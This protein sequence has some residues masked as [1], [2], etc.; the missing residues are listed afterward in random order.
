MMRTRLFIDSAKTFLTLANDIYVGKSLEVY[1]EWSYDEIRLLSCLLDTKSNVIE[2]GSNIG[3]HT[4]FIAKDI[5]PEGRLFAFEPRRLIFQLLNAN[6]ALNAIDNVFAYNVGLSDALSELCEG[7]FAAEGF[8]NFGGADLGSVKG[9]YEHIKIT[10]LDSYFHVMPKIS[11]IKADVEGY[12]H[13]LIMGAQRLIARDRPMLYLENDRPEA[14][15]ELLTHILG[16]NYNI[17]W[18]LAPLYRPDNRAMTQ[19]NIFQNIASH[20]IICLPKEGIVN[21]ISGLEPVTDPKKHPLMAATRPIA[22]P[23]S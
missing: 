5:C 15:E 18:H 23:T 12:E 2:A 3:A 13:R 9:D 6:L 1:G 20:N 7:N 4:V 10:T 14:S 11:M 21:N 22:M 8:A 19:V 16:L 17:W